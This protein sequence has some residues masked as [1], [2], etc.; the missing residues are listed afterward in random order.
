MDRVRDQLL[1]RARFAPH[2]HGRAGGSDLGHLVVEL[3]HGARVP[4]QAADLVALLQLV[5]ELGVL[6][7]QARPLRFHEPM[8][9]H[10]LAEHGA[11]DGQ[12]GRFLVVAAVLAIGKGD[13]ERP[14]RPPADGHGHADV[15]QLALAV[16]PQDTGA[17][18]E[19]GLAADLRNDDRAAALHHAARDAFTGLVVRA[20]RLLPSRA[21]GR[22][23]RQLVAVGLAQ[24]DRGAHRAQ[25]LL[26]VLED[27]AEGGTDVERGGEGLA[28]LEEVGQ[29]FGLGRRHGPG[30]L[31]NCQEDLKKTRARG[32]DGEGD[33]DGTGD[34]DRRFLRSPRRNADS[35]RTCG[36][37]AAG[38]S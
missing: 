14:H 20:P 30:I 16:R 18:E 29:D 12:A 22:L 5:P 27:A 1:A 23:H 17:V 13:S 26:D 24:R 36:G 33:G 9:A 35:G 6:L 15:G 21:D 10:G 11:H 25:A 4:D 3:L 32:L 19:Q 7:D 34:G 28:D 37:R 8:H 2:E 31:Q 38:T